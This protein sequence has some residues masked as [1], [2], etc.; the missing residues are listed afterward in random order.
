[1]Q[2]AENGA[3]FPPVIL[4]KIGMKKKVYNFGNFLS[5]NVAKLESPLT[6]DTQKYFWHKIEVTLMSTFFFR[7]LTQIL[8]GGLLFGWGG[9]DG[10]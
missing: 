3:A 2:I 4:H 5:N 7:E 9:G 6:C 8:Q 10:L 1:M